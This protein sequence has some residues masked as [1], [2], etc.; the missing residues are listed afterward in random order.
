MKY[1]EKFIPPQQ[2][3]NSH[4]EKKVIESEKEKSRKQR[5]AVFGERLMGHYL[6]G[7]QRKRAI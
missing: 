6:H 4:R 7:S 2:P 3:Q 5:K 1:N